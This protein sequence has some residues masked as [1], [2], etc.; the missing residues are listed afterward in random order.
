M[1]PVTHWISAAED[2]TSRPP[3]FAVPT[4]PAI[5][6][7]RFAAARRSAI[8][9]ND[10]GGMPVSPETTSAVAR[11]K[12]ARSSPGNGVF[13][14][15]LSRTSRSRKERRLRSLPGRME[16]LRSALAPVSD[17]WGSTWCQRK[18]PRALAEEIF[19]V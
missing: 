5:T 7:G 12:A 17:I 16:N 8:S 18:S 9:F 4:P 19:R 2:A 10:S 1:A 15:F 6:R 13:G 3:A 14:G 11:G